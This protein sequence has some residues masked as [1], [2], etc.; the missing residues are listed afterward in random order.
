MIELDKIFL[1]KFCVIWLKCNHC[2][3]K[4][5]EGLKWWIF[6]HFEWYR[7]HVLRQGC[8]NGERV[9]LKFLLFLVSYS[10]SYKQELYFQNNVLGGNFGNQ[11]TCDKIPNHNS[12]SGTKKR[13]T[14]SAIKS[15]NRRAELPFIGSAVR[16]N[17]VP[18]AK[19]PWFRLW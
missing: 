1:R 10:R 6:E 16:T 7:R 18:T 19:R 15:S 8:I 13:Q 14:K 11:Y 4:S 9:E 5:Y 17:L 12:S 3:C 2:F